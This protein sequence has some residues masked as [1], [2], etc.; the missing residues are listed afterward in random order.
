MII[1]SIRKV[2]QLPFDIIKRRNLN[3]GERVKSFGF[4]VISLFLIILFL[5]AVT[6][7]Q[8]RQE[9]ALNPVSVLGDISEADEQIIFSELQAQLGETYKLVPQNVFEEAHQQM[10]ADLKVDQCTEDYCIRQIQDI[11]QVERLFTLMMMRSGNLT[12][13]SLNLALNEQK[14][15]KTDS[16]VDCDISNLLEKVR[17]LAGQIVGEDPEAQETVAAGTPVYVNPTLPGVGVTAKIERLTP[18]VSGNRKSK[19]SALFFDSIPSG[20]EVY[21]GNDRAGSTPF[22]RMN[23]APSQRLL[24]TLK[25]PDYR[26]KIIEL[27]LSGGINKLQ[28]ITLQSKYGKLKIT[29]TPSGADVFLAGEKKG[30]TP[31]TD[32]H[33]LSGAYLAD[34][35]LSLYQSVESERIIVEDDKTTTRHFQ[36]TSNFGELKVGTEPAGATIRVFDQDNKEV[37]SKTSPATIRLNPAEYKIKLEKG[38]YESLEYNIGVSRDKVQEISAQDAILRRLEGYLIVSSDPYREDAVILINGEEKGLVPSEFTLPA[39]TYAIQVETEYLTGFR[40]VSI[41]D[42]ATETLSIPLS[43]KMSAAEIAEAHSSWKTK[44]MVSGIGTLLAAAWT[45]TEYQAALQAKADYDSEKDK[46]QS[47]ASYEEASAYNDKAEDYRA[48]INSHSNSAQLGALLSFGLTGLTVW[49]WLDEPMQSNQA[50]IAPF[51]TSQG[52]MGL[53]HTMI[54]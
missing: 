45:Y 44:T 10:M 2:I 5:P 35:R 30:I 6:W 13:L 17:S 38:G 54:F 11:L 26:D 29:S 14:I 12:H 43:D 42:G 27:T 20:A 50:V 23:L 24:V 21:L 49:F 40:E 46:T 37:A 18:I 52:K 28:P 8:T 51:I 32:N 48:A 36:M 41:G 33:I 15:V 53:I 34:I 4:P 47:A 39:G 31:F 22:Q 25:H 3:L 9:A 19:T 7:A 16:C 1:S